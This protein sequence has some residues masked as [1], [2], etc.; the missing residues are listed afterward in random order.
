M[1][2]S[3]WL[4]SPKTSG[5]FKC[6][7]FFLSV[8]SFSA[9]LHAKTI[10]GLDNACQFHSKNHGPFSI[11]VAA[12]HS[13]QAANR[14]KLQLA[15]HVH[16]PI[17]VKRAHK[18]YFVA[19][20]PLTSSA[21]VRKVGCST[22]VPITMNQSTKKVPLKKSSSLPKQHKQP[23]VAPVPLIPPVSRETLPSTLPHLPVKLPRKS[24]GIANINLTGS[25]LIGADIGIV[26]PTFN[27]SITV[28]N[29]S[30]YAAPENVDLY[31]TNVGSTPPLLGALIGYRW[32]RDETLFPATLLALRYQHLFSQNIKGQILQYSLPEFTNYNYT[33]DLN[34]NVVSLYSKID[35]A[36]YKRFMPYFALGLGAAINN[37]TAYQETALSGVTPRISPAF[38]S[39]TQTQ[40]AY[41]VGAG[42]D[43]LLTPK[44]IISL[45]YDYQ[46][47]GD[48]SS[49]AGQSTWAATQLSLG[50]VATNTATIGISYLID[51]PLQF[52]KKMLDK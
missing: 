28:P 21:M 48:L 29:G 44:W 9:P 32:Q 27:D 12:F 51:N 43:F 5:L 42:V 52:Y 3:N 33:W 25:W 13:M 6:S 16:Y 41:N 22:T 38:A 30:N 20:G 19:I 10:F 39:K 26:S 40:F 7:L 4:M 36:Q 17:Q 50:R 14:L 34:T 15:K 35:I 11:Q 2:K 47:F 1:I 23:L 24:T 49:G 18:N 37:A 46:S 31:T 45:G 8:F